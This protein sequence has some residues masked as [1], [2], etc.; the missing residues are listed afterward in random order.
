MDSSDKSDFLDRIREIKTVLDG[1]LSYELMLDVLIVFL[2]SYILLTIIGIFI[3]FSLLPPLVYLGVRGRRLSVFEVV[4]DP[5]RERMQTAY[6]NHKLKGNLIVEDLTLQ[7]S[8]EIDR[9]RYSSFLAAERLN[10]KIITLI[11]LC[12][13]LVSLAFLNAEVEEGFSDFADKLPVLAGKIAGL[14]GTGGIGEGAGDG[15]GNTVQSGA[16]QGQI[17]PVAKIV[18][19]DD[20]EIKIYQG[21]TR[22]IN[23]R[24]I[25]ESEP[26][27]EDQ[28]LFPVE[29]ESAS[30]YSE[31]ITHREVV[32]NYFKNL[33]Q[34]NLV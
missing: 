29:A 17:A 22:E 28:P 7:V 8:S 3:W 30:A 31:V 19:G 32:K 13:L 15:G 2:V 21:A 11:L 4:E 25:Q 24:D 18:G 1:F 34:S 14:G 20:L 26:P 5:L 10:R 23:V 9:L 33:S 12:F 6:D 27:F 16:G